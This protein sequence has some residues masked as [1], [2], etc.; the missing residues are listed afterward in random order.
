MSM[1]RKMLGKKAASNTAD[2]SQDAGEGNDASAVEVHKG[3]HVAVHGVLGDAIDDTGEALEDIKDAMDRAMEQNDLPDVVNQGEAKLEQKPDDVKFDHFEFS[4][5]A[6]AF[7]YVGKETSMYCFFG[8]AIVPNVPRTRTK[9]SVLPQF[10]SAL[11]LESKEKMTLQIP[12]VF[13]D[14]KLLAVRDEDLDKFELTITMWRISNWTFNTYHGRAVKKLSVIASRD[15]NMAIRVFE[16]LSKKDLEEKIKNRRPVSDVAVFH[17]NITLE[18]M[19]DFKLF[20]ENWSLTQRSDHPKYKERAKQLQHITFIIPKSAS[21]DAST[22]RRCQTPTL[23]KRAGV[24][25]VRGNDIVWETQWS[26]S[27]VMATFRG[28]KSSLQQ[29]YFI[30]HAYSTPTFVAA[31]STNIGSVLMN[32]RSVLDTSAFKSRVKS[33]NSGMSGFKVGDLDG[34]IRVVV[35]PLGKEYANKS[36]E[37][38][39]PK[40]SNSVFHLSSSEKHLVVCITKCEHLAA[41]DEEKGTS[42]PYAAVSWDSTVQYTPTLKDT[43]RPVFNHTFY[44]PVRFFNRKVLERRYKDFLQDELV[45]NKRVIKIDLWHEEETSAAHLGQ[46]SL[47]IKAILDSN[48]VLRRTIRGAVKSSEGDDDDYPERGQGKRWYDEIKEVKV[49]DGSQTPL[50][51]GRF[52]NNAQAVIKFE[53]YFWPEWHISASWDDASEDL[54]SETRFWQEKEKQFLA[55]NAQFADDYANFF[56][57]A[58]GAKEPQVSS[59][60]KGDFRTFPCLAL[61]PDTQE[62]VP[63]TRFLTAVDMPRDLS[64]PAMLLHWIS[65]ITFKMSSRQERTGLIKDDMWRDPATFMHT[66][67]GTPQDHAILLC[68]MLISAFDAYVVKGT[69]RAGK[70]LV[71][72]AWVM[73]RDRSGWITF[74]E[75]TTRELYHL[76]KRWSPK[77][78]KARLPAVEEKKDEEEGDA[79]ADDA[80]E[81]AVEALRDSMEAGVVSDTL[82]GGDDEDLPTVGRAPRPK[83]RAASAQSSREKSKQEMIAQREKVPTAP[84]QE[85]LREDSTLV[86]WLP[87]DS[88]DVVFNNQNIWANHQNHHPACITYDFEE[89][90][91]LGQTDVDEDATKTAGWLAFLSDEERKTCKLDPINFQV[92]GETAWPRNIVSQKQEQLIGD[93]CENIRLLRSKSGF[94]STFDQRTQLHSQL[95]LF[96]DMHETLRSLDIDHCPIFDKKR[97]QWTESETYLFEVLLKQAE[98]YNRQGS[99]FTAKASAGEDD[100][101]EAMKDLIRVDER[102]SWSKLLRQIEEFRKRKHIF[103]TKKEKKFTGFPLHFST[104][105][106]DTIRNYLMS[107]DEFFKMVHESNEDVLLTVYCKI[108]P[109][110]GGFSSTWLFFGTQLPLD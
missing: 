44:F 25:K 109:L 37:F 69:I 15:P 67:I 89:C 68:S 86:D 47:D 36:P 70:K 55:A 4:L 107:N 29:Q 43:L 7:E 108:F 40:L 79:E 84:K 21:S 39:Q 46:A 23:E 78:R 65:N 9:L 52:S 88:I 73:T 98:R 49:Y 50:M 35:C 1:A 97:E 99:A 85:L 11:H 53:A 100:Q 60:T 101:F 38:Q 32:L 93:I 90:K 72:H 27:A 102:R 2:V 26:S 104:T 64:R 41:A 106:K 71:E 14:R 92:I 56:P 3:S 54:D 51:G 103:P 8:I 45:G 34:N 110:W 18:Q 16:V 42:S 57:D 24:A 83:Q 30:G 10:T 12:D 96:V 66:K 77:K 80:E 81:E 94:D 20:Y 76:P 31:M 33:L 91:T 58:I 5:S 59:L 28:T 22:K 87:Y 105:A 74:W 62:P 6:L 17:A 19:F 95:E 61:H 82:V 13:Y 48:Q 63:L 75:P